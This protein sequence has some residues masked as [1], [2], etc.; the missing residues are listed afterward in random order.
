VVLEIFLIFID[1]GRPHL[2]RWDMDGGVR[3]TESQSG[4]Y[5]KESKQIITFNS[6]GI[7]VPNDKKNYQYDINK[8]KDTFRILIFGD[9]MAEGLQV[10]F[11][12]RFSH[13]MEK[14]LNN[15]KYKPKEKVEIINFSLSGTGQAR[16]FEMQQGFAKKYETDIILA[17]AHSNDPRN[18]F[19]KL[20]PG[21]F[22]PYWTLKNGN[23]VI[24]TSFR[25]NEVFLKKL[26]YSNL[27][28]KIVNQSRVLQLLTQ[29]YE[30]YLKKKRIKFQKKYYKELF[31]S[32]SI[33]YYL[34]PDWDE[35]WDIF[36][37][38]FKMWSDVLAK[39]NIP[40]YVSSSYFSD[41]F[42]PDDYW[43]ENFGEKKKDFDYM[44]KVESEKGGYR[45]LP[46]WSYM[47]K[48]P[49]EINEYFSVHSH[50][51]RS[52]LTGKRVKEVSED[53]SE[54][55]YVKNSTGHYNLIGHREW[56]VKMADELCKVWE[57][58]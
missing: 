11:Y 26:K 15:C 48:R 54:N 14:E 39:D 55:E 20:E 4:Y 35:A 16:Q 57:E 56:G 1:Y 7:R 37:A 51:Q 30:V 38:G 46:V 12:E 49:A 36:I 6:Q 58:Q 33:P 34:T 25:Q 2:S 52:L 17:V 45:Y 10:T 27:R 23:I 40:L 41:V 32:E 18:N 9:S 21:I 13:I 29:G 44:M 5:V 50:K 22:Y 31:G 3:H 42:I 8:P 28:M 19:S 43:G 24:D 47:R 53:L